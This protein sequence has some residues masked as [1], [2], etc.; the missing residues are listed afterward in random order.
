MG[1]FLVKLGYMVQALWCRF[2]CNWN[3]F[4]AKFI[5]K[6]ENCPNQICSCKK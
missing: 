3:S 6:V 4:V 2:Q 5:F 1:K